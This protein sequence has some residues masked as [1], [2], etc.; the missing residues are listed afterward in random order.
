M[1][2]SISG[3]MHAHGISKIEN[4][5]STGVFGKVWMCLAWACSGVRESVCERLRSFRSAGASETGMSEMQMATAAVGSD[6]QTPAGL[7]DK[8]R[9]TAGA[10]WQRRASW[11]GN[12]LQVP[13]H[14]RERMACQ[15]RS[16]HLRE[17]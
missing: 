16:D 4:S 8:K 14:P 15:I 12:A 6:E 10:S 17:A 2:P 9:R 1:Q 3:G 5:E 11:Q 7:E 13:C